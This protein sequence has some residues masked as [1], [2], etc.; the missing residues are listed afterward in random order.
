MGS[1]EATSTVLQ[2]GIVG[3]GIAGLAA[4]IA[5]RRAGHEIDLYEKSTF[6]NEIGAA[7]TITPNGNLVLDRWGFDAKR[8]RETRKCQTRLVNPA[9]LAEVTKLTFN[10]IAEQ[11]G[12]HFNAYH[13]VDM[14]EE[15]RR[16]AQDAGAKIHLGHPVDDV[17]CERGTIKLKGG[18]TLKKDL[19]VVADGI[20]S[21]IVDAIT[22][23]H[24]PSRKSPYSVYRTLIPIDRLMADPLTQPLWKNQ[25]SGFCNAMNMQTGTGCMTYPCRDD[26]LMNF[27]YFHRTKPHEQD[28]DSWHSR[29]TVED[30]LEVLDGF[31]PAFAAIAKHADIMNC[32]VVGTR[33]VLP[34]MNGGKAVLIGDAAHAMMPTHAMG[35]SMCLEDAAALEVLFSKWQPTD[36]VSA[37]LNLYN[38]LRLPRNAVTQ[39]A[40]NAMIWFTPLAELQQE[41]RK[42]WDGP[43]QATSVP[44]FSKPIQ[45]FW[46]GYDAFAAAEK[47]MDFKDAEGG[48]PDG[49]VEHFGGR[50]KES[51]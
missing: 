21:G 12:H 32:Y 3:A 23:A 51:G 30:V 4:A 47:A 19:I 20:S 35:G 25:E 39:L 29:S 15:M 45:E 31:H 6:K 40:S 17:D 9:D 49:V 50:T 38:Q 46:F 28:N 41:I 13:R 26:T 43:L 42:Y 24:C 7:I 34:C 10:D 48:L 1:K 14:H 5:L 44:P 18:E 33:D 27:A 22:G 16:L 8:A 11:Y 2:C 36:S 37:R